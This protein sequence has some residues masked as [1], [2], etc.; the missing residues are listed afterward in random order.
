VQGSSRALF[1]AQRLPGASMV[2]FYTEE[3]GAQ[4]AAAIE[5]R[6]EIT[7]GSESLHARLT[8]D[9]RFVDNTYG[10]NAIGWSVEEKGKGGKARELKQ[11][12]GS[13]HATLRMLDKSANTALEFKVDYISEADDSSS[14]YRSLGVLGGDGKMVT[15]DE[16]HVLAASTSL[17][18][19]FNE[20]GYQDYF[21]S[22]PATDAD[23]TPNPAAPDWEFH[24]AYDVWVD[25]KAF[26]TGFGDAHVDF[27]HAS[28]SKTGENT[29][30][31][32]RDRCPPDWECEMDGSCGEE[33]PPGECQ[34]DADCAGDELCWAFECEPVLL[35]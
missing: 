24:V 27:I 3:D 5:H 6:L 10:E 17:D 23:Y 20:L 11:L 12:I 4:P 31:V 9:P 1:G 13:D 8:L 35:Q 26:D 15:G 19:N 22:S 29:V 32:T 21:V 30:T 2:C 34:S 18:R 33:P 16:S 28:P 14:G 7:E 25:L